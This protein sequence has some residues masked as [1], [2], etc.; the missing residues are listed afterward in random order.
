MDSLSKIGRIKKSRE[1]K[2][3]FKSGSRL[4]TRNIGIC[5][6]HS[7]AAA[8]KP[9]GA[10]VSLPGALCA[11]PKKGEG[12]KAFTAW[13]IGLAVSKKVGNAVTRNRVKRILREAFRLEAASVDAGRLNLANP[14]LTQRAAIDGACFSAYDVVLTART[15]MKASS[16]VEVRKEIG[17]FLQRVG[18]G[19]LEKVSRAEVRPA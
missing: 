7:Y 6:M 11:P 10:N 9:L 5:Y 14:A 4:S 3:V 12:H 16:F 17:Y 15:N 19:S 2:S 1:F 13:R 8:E 18:K